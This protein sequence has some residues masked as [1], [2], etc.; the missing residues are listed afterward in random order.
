MWG[1]YGGVGVCAVWC[2]GCGGFQGWRRGGGRGGLGCPA[3]HYGICVGT[4][5]N[6]TGD[7][8]TGVEMEKAFLMGEAPLVSGALVENTLPPG[9]PPSGMFGLIPIP[10]C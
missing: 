7:G 1:V 8:H 2:G 3:G 6:H 10:W 9:F 4:H 5:L